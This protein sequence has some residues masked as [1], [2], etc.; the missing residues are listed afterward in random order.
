MT[1][2][3]YKRLQNQYIKGLPS[4]TRR[5]LRL[6][7]QGKAVITSYKFTNSIKTRYEITASDE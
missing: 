7:K 2:K 3:E 4:E 5:V 1:L 6:V